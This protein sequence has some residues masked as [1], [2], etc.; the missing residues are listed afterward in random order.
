MVSKERKTVEFHLKTKKPMEELETV[1]GELYRIGEYEFRFTENGLE[2]KKKKP[3]AGATHTRLS[4]TTDKRGKCN[5]SPDETAH[6]YMDIAPAE[7]KGRGVLLAE[8]IMEVA[9]ELASS[10]AEI[11][12]SPLLEAMRAFWK[13]VIRVQRNSQNR[14]RK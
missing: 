3:N 13:E 11:D 14:G 9:G 7:Y 2:V 5:L 10:V 12:L 4:T 8:Q 6:V 1:K